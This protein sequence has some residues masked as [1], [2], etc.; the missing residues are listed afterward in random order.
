MSTFILDLRLALRLLRK[1][2]GVA[3]IAV[4]T[5][6]LGIGLTTTMFSIVHGGLRELPF[7]ESERLVHLERNH[8]AEGI[9]S[10][11]VT[12][13]DF[14]DWRQRQTSFESLE[15]YYTGTANLAS[16]GQPP[17][18]Y[19]AA[20]LTAGG[21]GL[22]GVEPALGRTFLPEEEGVSSPAVVILGHAV[23][24]DRFGADPGILGET[25]RINGAPHTVVG[26]MP[27]GFRFPF[28]HDLWLP[29][30]Q[31]V[32]TLER[33]EGITLEVYGRL[34]D[35]V[36]LDQ[37]G[38]EMAVI[39]AALA[40]EHPGTN[41]GI[42]SVIKPYVDEFTGQEAKSI[43]YTML[44]AVFGVL[45]I[46]CVNVANLLLARA[47]TRTSEVAVRSALGA[48]RRQVVV[49]MLT[50]SAVL[51]AVGALL[52]LALAVFGV[53]WIAR[54]IDATE[55]PFW[56][57]IRI[58]GTV[59]GF[60]LGITVL[61]ALL[62]GLVPALRVSGQQP[63]R[64]LQGEGRGGPGLRLGRLSRVL[65]VAEIALTCALLLGAGLMIRSVTNLR[66]MDL[67]IPVDGVFTARVGLFETDYP[68][69]E[70]Q[71]AFFSRLQERLGN[72]P[73]V[74]AATVTSNLPV[75]GGLPVRLEVEGR[76]YP[77]PE[78]RP[79]A[80]RVIAAPA[81]LETFER[82]PL[83]GREFGRRD[84]ADSLPVALINRSLAERLFPEDPLNAPLGSR[85]RLGD[86]T[87]GGGPDGEEA[88]PWRTVVGVVP[89]LWLDGLDDEE[90]E[91][92]YVPLAQSEIR[93]ASLAVRPAGGDPMDLAPAVRGEVQALDPSLP[94]YWTR[95]LG[96]TIQQQTWFY[97]VF[98][99][100]FML[101]GAVALFLA[102]VGL[103]GVMSF[104]VT[105]RTREVGVRMALGA[106][107][108]DVV[109]MVLRQGL[110]QLGVGLVAG[111]GLA[112]AFGRLLEALL[113]RVQPEDPLT[114]SL[115][116]GVLAVSGLL[117]TLLP[118]RR[119]SR[120]DPAVA[121]RDG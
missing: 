116:V 109:R 47:A 117:A 93:F 55:P 81:L 20:F 37:A 50:E 86:G 59:L 96:Q 71:R 40:E 18:R 76:A 8:L 63:G 107:A 35:G 3:G 80:R 95:T 99:G 33:G 67:G 108:A 39:A 65:V 70:E 121:L 46:C 87:L 118:A 28:D 75:L 13:H 11:E 97:D 105:R 73:G 53:D 79:R 90:P 52:G 120:V 24:Q 68:T 4:L 112:W 110:V 19:E 92:V 101:L 7:E 113:F 42:S 36:T 100:L 16:P 15:G 54:V 43:L 85:I 72:L 9:D 10:M 91:G 103:Y 106:R 74:E 31:D 111:L 98:G 51:A 2:A 62:S 114:F 38:Q 82:E 89:D 12:L 14:H 44:G 30:T 49:Q 26:V 57:D 69:V 64:V 34:K 78:D 61:A 83:A 29:L 48:S 25:V 77:R 23:W 60:T 56:V 41:E 58:D 22:L 84:R 104:A 45:L 115:V 66:G 21:L 27:E 5:F 32:A 88:E 6:A 17:E 102:A 119:A 1:Q 94:I